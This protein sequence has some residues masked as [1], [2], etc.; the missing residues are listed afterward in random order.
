MQHGLF[1]LHTPQKRSAPRPCQQHRP[2]ALQCGPV[3]RICLMA[4]SIARP[5]AAIYKHVLEI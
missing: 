2:Y 5:I 3:S 4:I 1:H